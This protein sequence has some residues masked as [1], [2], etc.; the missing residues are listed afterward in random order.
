VLAEYLVDC[1]CDGAPPIA[2]A[3]HARHVVEIML[4]AQKSARM[5][6]AIELATVFWYPRQ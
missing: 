5:E 1:L 3:E 6:R 2:S 4:K